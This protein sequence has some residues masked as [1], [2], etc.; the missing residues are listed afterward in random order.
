VGEPRLKI[1]E[2]RRGPRFSVGGRATIYC[3]PFEGRAITGTLR[4]LSAG[5]VCLD[6]GHALELGARTELLV[7]V[8]AASFRAAALVKGQTELSS[9]CLQFVQISEGGRGVLEDLIERFTKLRML[10]RKLRST[11]IDEETERRLLDKR[12]FRMVAVGEGNG[13]TGAAVDARMES[14]FPRCDG[15]REIA[16]DREIIQLKPG[17][18]QIDLFG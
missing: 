5:G 10:N 11:E 1:D 6:I 17:L 14:E 18:I 12:R 9:A 7:S 3:L 8:N 15:E 4:N 13:S 16:I 2:R